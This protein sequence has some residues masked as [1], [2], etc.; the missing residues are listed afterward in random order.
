M[1]QQQLRDG[2]LSR[3]EIDVA[4]QVAGG[5]MVLDVNMGAPLVDEA[6]LMARAVKLI[7]GRTDLPLCIDSSIIEVLDAGLAA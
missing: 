5:A 3:V 2:D 6:E 7:Q 4:E 1:F